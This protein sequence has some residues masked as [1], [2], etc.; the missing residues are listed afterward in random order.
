MDAKLTLIGGT[1]LERIPVSVC[2]GTSC[3]LNGS[4]DIL[5]GLMEYVETQGLEEAVQL[6][7]TFCMEN[8]GEGPS[9]CVGEEVLKR[10]TLPIA[11]EALK[12]QVEQVGVTL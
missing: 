1:E 5:K 2:V 8:C 3:F 6:S 7:A 11:I 9:V 12:A 4:Q 10:C